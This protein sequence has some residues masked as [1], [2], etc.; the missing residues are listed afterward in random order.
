MGR[1]RIRCH[2]KKICRYQISRWWDI[3]LHKSLGECGLK[4]QDATSQLLELKK[5]RTLTTLNVGKDSKQKEFSSIASGTAKWSPHSRVRLAAFLLSFIF[6]LHKSKH[7]LLLQ[8]TSRRVL[9]YLSKWVRNSC[10]HKMLY[11]DIYSSFANSWLPK[12][13]SKISCRRWMNKLWY[14]QTMGS[15][16]TKRGELRSDLNTQRN[17][18]STLLN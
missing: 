9:W 8:S 15:S 1:Y 3:L 4:Q 12:L 14:S 2:T 5:C 16:T 17:L 13:K 6:F 10:S 11:P 18:K 7:T